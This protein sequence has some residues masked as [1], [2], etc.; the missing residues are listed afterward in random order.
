MLGV[1]KLLGA[2]LHDVRSRDAAV[3]ADGDFEFVRALADLFG[4]PEH[5]AVRHIAHRLVGQVDGL[6]LDALNR[7][8]AD[9]GAAFKLFIEI[10]KH[11]IAPLLV[12][13]HFT[14][15]GGKSQY[16]NFSSL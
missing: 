14:I 9:I 8:A 11:M 10:V 16:A 3:P 7:Y 2:Q 1:D 5:K 6:S 13:H 12:C 4:K 15:I